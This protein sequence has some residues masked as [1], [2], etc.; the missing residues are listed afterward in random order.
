MARMLKLI[1]IALIASQ[2]SGCISVINRT[3]MGPG[4][5]YY[6]PVY[7][8]TISSLNTIFPSDEAQCGRNSNESNRQLCIKF[9][10]DIG[11]PLAMVDLPFSFVLDTLLLPVDAAIYLTQEPITHEDGLT[12]RKIKKSNGDIVKAC[13]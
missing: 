13:Y 4:H 8:G 7:P 12:C 10:H 1:F 3:T 9:L 5:L 6:P 2:I 11:R